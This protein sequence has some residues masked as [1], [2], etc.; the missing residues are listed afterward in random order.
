MT[1]LT[2]QIDFLYGAGETKRF[3]TW[4]VLRERTIA[5]HSWH[6]AMLLY[7]LYGQE[8]PGLRP[9]LILAAL[10]HDAAEWKVGDLPSPGKRGMAEFFPDF[11]EK[12]DKMEESILAPVGLDWNDLLD[13]EER[14]RLKF[15]DA[16]EGA[17]Y[18]IEDRAMGNKLI[19]VP[20]ENFSSYLSQLAPF[21]E[22][23]QEVFSYTLA[24]WSEANVG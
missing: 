5:H 1:K 18:C 3:H 13:D 21:S 9:A 4:P 7:L 16:L 20:Y 10:C 17:F 11:R 6:V 23:E 19:G 24:M 14:R 12:W 15:C 8:E 22:T 2:D